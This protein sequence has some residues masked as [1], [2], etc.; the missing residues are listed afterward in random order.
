[1]KGM[2]RP[3]ATVLPDTA[4]VPGGNVIKPAPNQF[5][6]ELVGTVPYHYGE[7]RHGGLPDGELATGS[8]VILLWHGGGPRCRVADGR[9]LYVEIAL[10]SLRKL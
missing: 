6:H 5:T 1:M 9:G 10:A 8:K 4:L 3:K 2:R 7:A